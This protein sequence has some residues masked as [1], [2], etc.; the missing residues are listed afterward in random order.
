MVPK[1]DTLTRQLNSTVP[2]RK[3]RIAPTP[4]GFLHRGNLANF[5]LNARL[6]GRGGR[7]LLRIDDLDRGRFRQAYLTDI[8]RVLR[9]LAIEIDEGP[10]DERDFAANWSQ[11]HRLASYE[12]AL[13][14]LA[15]DPLVFACPCS[16]KQ[17]AEGEHAHNCLKA[18]IDKSTP[19]VAWRVDTRQLEDVRI[20]DVTG[21]HFEVSLHRA[22]PDF[23]IRTKRALPAY[24]L[25]CTVDDLHY[26]ITD[27][28]RGEDL[29]ASTAAQAVLADR[30]GYAPLFERIGF[31]HHPLVTDERGVKMSKRAGQLGEPL[32][33]TPALVTELRA[34]AKRWLPDEVLIPLDGNGSGIK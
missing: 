26:G 9:Q 11:Q 10:V 6:A 1:S 33:I 7:L 16:R 20:P 15:K 28:G 31:V 25:A 3:A 30:L 19:G 23:A 24:Q 22:M 4:S 27:A 12:E 14:M 2:V 17:L 34:L 32:A 13:N 18:T 21:K 8:F 29:L 5:L